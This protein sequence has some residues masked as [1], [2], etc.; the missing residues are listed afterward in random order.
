MAIIR[1][2]IFVLSHELSHVRGPSLVW[3]SPREALL[4]KVIDRDGVAGWG[5]AYYRRGLD[6]IVSALGE[7]LI[8]KAP[9]E[10][11]PLVAAM[12]AETYDMW[13]VSAL[14]L[15]LDDLRARRLGVP[16][17]RL[18]GGHV[19]DR[20]RAY[21][22]SGGYYKG[23]DPAESWPREVNDLV[24]QGFTAIK[25]RI[26]RYPVAYEAPLLQRLR[27]QIPEEI[28][29]MADGNYAYTHPRAVQMGRVLEHLGFRWFEEPTPGY[30]SYAGYEDLA[31]T[32]DLPLAA[33]EGLEHR[34]QFLDFIGRRGADIIQPDVCMVGGIADM[35]FIAE[36]AQLHS[37]QFVPHCFNGAIS[38]AA[39]LQVLACVD[40]PTRQ[41][42][43]EDAPLL[44]FD[45]S[46]NP[47]LREILVEPILPQDGWVTIPQG[48]GLGIEV[49]ETAVRRL[50]QT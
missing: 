5:E 11:R 39:T 23:I 22:S 13:A 36:L 37:I 33:G 30:P 15:A 26:G 45:V 41:P 40:N 24:S 38:L 14:S 1:V 9:D 32:L 2:E 12:K 3:F 10:A 46:E 7:N 25:M 18:Y 42:A 20:V 28:E 49:D 27:E 34:G 16:V 48:P 4:V 29:L 19:R 44:E 17:Y 8:G 6:A 21:A 50:A 47:I 43:A 31:H 35:L